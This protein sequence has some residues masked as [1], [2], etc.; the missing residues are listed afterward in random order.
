M[1]PTRNDRELRNGDKLLSDLPSKEPR[2]DDSKLPA[3]EADRRPFED[4]PLR[5]HNCLLDNGPRTKRKPVLNSLALTA[6]ARARLSAL[7]P[8]PLPAGEQTHSVHP[9]APL[10]ETYRSATRTTSNPHPRQP[11]QIPAAIHSVVIAAQGPSTL[12]WTTSTAQVT[13][14]NS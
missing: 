8:Q 12:A 3:C 13:R 14:P 10:R 2:K 11:N 1:D 6:A 9:V 4:Q 5:P 7:L